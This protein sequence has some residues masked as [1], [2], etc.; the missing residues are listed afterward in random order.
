MKGSSF[1]FEAVKGS[2]AHSNP[3]KFQ[4]LNLPL[5]LKINLK[6]LKHFV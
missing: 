1:Y 5:K 6:L 4:E 2:P 3:E